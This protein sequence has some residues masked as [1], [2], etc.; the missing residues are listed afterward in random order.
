MAE[1]SSQ[2]M[3]LRAR[4]VLPVEGPPLEHG[5]VT[6]AGER[7]LQVGPDCAGGGTVTDLGEVALVPGLV[8][9]HTHLEFSDCKTP[10]GSSASSFAEWIGVV[11]RYRHERT[12]R[13]ARA[14][15]RAIESGVRESTASGTTT[16]GEIATAGWRLANTLAGKLEVVAFREVIALA[17]ERFS[18]MLVEVAHHRQQAT[19]RA[20]RAGISPHAP[21]TVHPELFARLVDDAREGDLPVAMHLAESIDELELLRS[22]S[23]PMVDYLA[24]RGFWIPGAIAPGTRP[25]D[26]L[27]KLAEAPRSLV[28]HGNYLS[29]DEVALVAEHRERMSVVYCPRTHAY[30]GHERHPIERILSAGGNVALG[31]DSRASNPDLSMLAEMHCVAKRHPALAPAQIVRLGTLAGAEALGVRDDVGSI[32]VGKRANL[33]VIALDR[34]RAADPYE[35]IFDEGTRVTAVMVR[36]QWV[37]G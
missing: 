11:T 24:S 3:H 25:R 35:V 33:A 1:G 18:E 17:S 10:L 13:D 27:Q 6:I 30:F 7:I 19:G 16:L 15:E 37:T 9:A 23:G 8:N 12:E 4:W 14:T 22:G 26:Y 5:V 34:P 20:W 28:V 21:Y 2:V 36:G 31:T 29:N 32:R